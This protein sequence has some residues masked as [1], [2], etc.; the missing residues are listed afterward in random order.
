[1]RRVPLLALLLTAAL[2]GSPLGAGQGSGPGGAAP[3]GAPGGPDAAP[4]SGRG[5]PEGRGGRGGIQIEAG[6]VCPP[7]TTETRPLRCQ[8]PEFPPPSIVDYQPRSTLV[9][10]THLVPRAKF[11]A[12]D[13]HGHGAGMLASPEGLAGLIEELDKLNVRVFVSADNSSGER[14]TRALE[15]INASPHR[16]RVR[17]LTGIQFGEVEPGF[18]ARAARQ[19]EADVQA[20]AVGV[21]EISKSFGL[22]IRKQDGSRLRVDDPELDPVW[23]VSARLNIPA[24]IH[25][26]EPQEFFSALDMQNERWLELSLFRDR[27]NFEAGQVTF[28]ELM[29]ERDNL[30]R[31]HPETTFIAAHFAWHANDLGRLSELLDEFPNVV[32]EA[33]AILYDLGRQPRAA[34]EFFIKYQ[35]RVLFGKDSFQPSEYPYYWRVFETNDEYFDY[36]RDYHAFWKLYGMGLPDDVLKK[37]YYANA[38]RVVPGLPRTGWPE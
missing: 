12:V 20:G 32:V 13:I 19:I 14:L 25:T 8:A 23:E 27:R 35:D 30:F 18:G 4:Q 5:G 37:V 29:D 1:M 38:L 33:G 9:T 34:R 26:A 2:V 31:R 28:E 15:V 21:G 10:E 3:A 24:F 7:G 6:E 17:M 16:D 22:T 36:Y 11:P